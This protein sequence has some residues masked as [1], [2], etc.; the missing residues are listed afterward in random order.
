MGLREVPAFLQKSVNFHIMKLLLSLIFLTLLVAVYCSD[1]ES[2]V[3]PDDEAAEYHHRRHHHGHYPHV[4]R[5]PARRWGYPLYGSEDDV[6]A[7]ED[8]GEDAEE[9]AADGEEEEEVDS[10]GQDEDEVSEYGVVARKIHRCEAR[11]RLGL[12]CRSHH[13]YPRTHYPH[14]RG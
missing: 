13:V 8:Q 14:H 6:G 1:E 5:W 7:V 4:R 10:A 2:Q 12:P 11:R 3:A 9:V